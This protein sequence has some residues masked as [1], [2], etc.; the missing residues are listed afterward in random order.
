MPFN[1]AWKEAK[2]GDKFSLD[3]LIAWLERQPVDGTYNYRMPRECLLAQYYTEMYGEP[4]TVT[5][6][7]RHSA[8]NGSWFNV[9]SP[10][11]FWRVASACGQNDEWSFKDA[12]R[13][14][15]EYQNA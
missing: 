7:G 3:T 10:D 12:L 6:M 4:V 8:I 15:R 9:P 5:S 2:T 1:P 13:R 11:T 14:A